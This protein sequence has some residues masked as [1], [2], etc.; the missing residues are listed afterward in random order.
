MIQKELFEKLYQSAL[1]GFNNAFVPYSNFRVGASILLKNGELINGCNVE[2]ASYGLCNCAE[3]T[4][5]F[6]AYSQ[7]V[8]KNDIECMM[9]LAAT[10]GPVSPCGACRQVMSELLKAD[11]LV[12]LTNLKKDV[13]EMTVK[14]LLPYAFT[15]D[16][17]HE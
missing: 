4:A 10:D 8:R 13:K 14:D 1:D 11:T 17:L 9:V 6:K 5:L 12:I 2:N 16:N 7:G 15:E 3:R